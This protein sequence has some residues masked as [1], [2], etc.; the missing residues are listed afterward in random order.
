MKEL[1]RVWKELIK[2]E[3]LIPLRAIPNSILYI[4]NINNYSGCQVTWYAEYLNKWT[5]IILHN[6]T[7]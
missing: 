7:Q 2:C 3:V 4:Q 5:I 6:S 1:R